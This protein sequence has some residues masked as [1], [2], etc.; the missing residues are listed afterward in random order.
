MKR[1][2]ALPLLLQNGMCLFRKC[3][4]TAT[5]QTSCH[6]VWLY[7]A[8][9]YSVSAVNVQ[10]LK[11]QHERLKGTAAFKVDMSGEHF[12]LK[13]QSNRCLYLADTF[14]QSDSQVKN[15]PRLQR[16]VHDT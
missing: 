10:Q 15:T 2:S 13:R 12:I 1:L 4:H 5:S 9:Y 14:I 8:L 11:K 7:A 3:A 16:L 6:V